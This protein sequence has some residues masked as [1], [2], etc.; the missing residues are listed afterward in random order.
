MKCA[1]SKEKIAS[2]I[3]TIINSY[4]MLN[5]I[6]TYIEPFVGGANI[7]DKVQ[8][9][10]KLAYDNNRHLIALFKYLQENDEL[11]L[12]ITREQYL[13]CKAHFNK[14]DGYYPDWYLAICGIIMGCGNKLYE[15]NYIN[16]Q[17]PEEYYDKAIKD[18]REQMRSLM[19]TK[20]EVSDYSEINPINSLIYCDAPYCGSKGINYKSK[21]FNYKQYWD[22]IRAWS[23]NNIVIVSEVQAPDDFDI[24]WIQDGVQKEN[25][26]KLFMHHSL[27]L[28][29]SIGDF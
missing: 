20:F 22:I 7:I 21:Q 2:E 17:D 26:E 10:T 23:K 1:G 25:A 16:S 3:V 19:E 4:I 6:D 12:E 24:I 18:L 11:P 28:D 27:N 29:D 15:G 5:N 9:S 8:C 14:N 13:D